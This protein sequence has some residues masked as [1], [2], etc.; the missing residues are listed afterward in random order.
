[1]NEDLIRMIKL[2]SKM[3]AFH[4]AAGDHYEHVNG[5][6]DWHVDDEIDFSA[7]GVYSGNLVRKHVVF[8]FCD[9]SL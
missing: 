6:Y 8:L 7:R 5:G 2:N 3:G 9:T 1:M 4:L